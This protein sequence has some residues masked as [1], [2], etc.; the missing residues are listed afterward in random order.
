[1]L[2][3]R[4]KQGF[5]SKQFAPEHQI[6]VSGS[7]TLR[8]RFRVFAGCRIHRSHLISPYFSPKPSNPESQNY[9]LHPSTVSALHPRPLSPTSYILY[10][11]AVKEPNVKLLHE[12]NYIIL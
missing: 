7:D 5:G 12:G 8:R 11:V 4:K 6:E 2:D 10:W 3:L 9:R 1:M